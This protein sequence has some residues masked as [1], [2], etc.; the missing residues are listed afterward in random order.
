MI[1][2]IAVEEKSNEITA[3]PALLSLLDIRGSV[4]TTDAMSCQKATA[5]QIVEQGGDYVLALKGNHPHLSEDVA[6]CLSRLGAARFLSVLFT[7]ANKRTM[8]MA[9]RRDA[10]ASACP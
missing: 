8:D 1:G 6:L 7:R 10:L 5:Q 9:G 3:V 4:I 2:Q